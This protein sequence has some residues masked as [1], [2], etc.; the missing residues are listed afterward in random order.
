M[1]TKHKSNI[2]PTVANV[3]VDD[4]ISSSSSVICFYQLL[5]NGSVATMVRQHISMDDL[6]TNV[7]MIRLL[8]NHDN[9]TSTTVTMVD[10]RRHNSRN[11]TTTMVPPL[12]PP[13]YTN[14][15]CD[16]DLLPPNFSPIGYDDDLGSTDDSNHHV[17]TMTTI[18]DVQVLG[19]IPSCT[20]TRT[21]GHSDDEDND[22]VVLSYRV[23]RRSSSSS[24]TSNNTP[25]EEE[26]DSYF[27]TSIPWHTTLHSVSSVASMALPAQPRLLPKTT[28][29][30]ALVSSSVL[31]VVTMNNEMYLYDIV[32]GGLIYTCS[33]LFPTIGT[34]T[35]TATPPACT[36]IQLLSDPKHA[37]VAILY[38][39][40][41]DHDFRRSSNNNSNHHHYWIAYTSIRH[42][43]MN[44]TM[45]RSFSH[46]T[47]TTTI[48]PP[49]SL[50]MGLAMSFSIQQE[51]PS[52]TSLLFQEPPK[53]VRLLT[54]TLF[55]N[56]HDLLHDRTNNEKLRLQQQRSITK[57]TKEE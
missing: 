50:A 42:A 11:A 6:F 47:T 49:I 4:T 13:P 8:Q 12:L 21:N 24:S 41:P 53:T 43:Y 20:T 14:S 45:S 37:R 46:A 54:R 39:Y 34:T 23:V 19:F 28:R 16:W 5:Y 52:A 48:Q 26:C 57:G 40:N 38:Q 30:T 51:H 33:L 7:E 2:D 25:S 35:T 56:D 10:H 31:G 22:T 36:T 17:G 27:Y 9:S 29:L 15:C 55:Q 32:R 1:T 18:A 44:G 3:G